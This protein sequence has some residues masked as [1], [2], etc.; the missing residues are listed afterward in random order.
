MADG[1]DVLDALAHASAERPLPHRVVVVAAHPDDEAIGVG[2]VLARF[3]CPFVVHV[4]DG[5]PLDVRF[6]RAAGCE[7]REEY[8]RV[9][10]SERVRALSIAGVTADRRVGLG[11]IDLESFRSLVALTTALERVFAALRPHVVITHAYEG[12]HSDHDAAAFIVR[13]AVARAS[14]VASPMLV[15]MAAY[16]AGPD[17]LVIGTFLG[18]RARGI[19]MELD[20][21]ERQR[22][23]RMFDAHASQEMVLEPFRSQLA[24]ERLRFAPPVRFD[25]APHSGQTHYERIGLGVPETDFRRSAR[26]AAA[27]LGLPPRSPWRP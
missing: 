19:E 1:S 16:H 3:R 10:D 22:K 8:L 11:A 9:R 2:G 25:H 13:A 7:S 26:A 20:D 17:G 6:A 5:A 18:A 4:T 27:T 12:G 23:A 21:E 14:A 24:I 15:E